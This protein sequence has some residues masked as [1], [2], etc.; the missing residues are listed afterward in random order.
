MS[1]SVPQ[2]ASVNPSTLITVKLLY[3]DNTRRFKIPLKELDAHVLPQKLRQLL[4]VPADVNVILERYSDSAGCYI[5][6]DSENNAVY[7]Q[8]YR[9]AK[10]K[11][12]LRIKVTEVNDTASQSPLPVEDSPDYPN[13]TRYSY[14]ETVLSSPLPEG[15]AESLYDLPHD[16]GKAVSA[17]SS[18]M[19][20]SNADVAASEEQ[21][22]E[23]K[24]DQDSLGTPVVSHK[25]PTG[26]FCIDCNHCGRSIPNEHYHCSICDD[27][28]YDL[29][30][31][32]VDS[33]LTCPNENHW[34]IRRIVTDGIV[35]NSITETVAPRKLQVDD[36]EE[37]P[38]CVEKELEPV[39]EPA[40]EDIP[41]TPPVAPEFPVQSEAR[42][43]NACLK[44][45]DETKMVTC[46]KCKDYDLCITCLLKDAH[47]HHPAHNFSLLHDRPF[48]LKNL[49]LSR[50]KPGR[51]YQH[52]AICDGCEKKNVVG[53]R[54]KCLTCPDWDY[55]TECFSNAQETHP[56]HRFAPLYEAIAEP[57]QS[58]EVH[59]G[60]FCDGPL[61][62]NKTVPGYI[63]GVR[64]KCS[65]CYD[66]DFCSNCEALP[67]NTHNRT[68]PMVMLK[69]PVRNV[70]VSTL[71]EDRFGGST[72]TLGDRAQRSTSTQAVNPV[73]PEVP[74]PGV[75]V[76]EESVLSQ[77]SNSVEQARSPSGEQ[78]VKSEKPDNNAASG[79][80]A[81]FMRDTVP[82]STIMPPN[83][84][85][86]Q[87]WTL[88]NP[89][90]LAWPAG[91]NV[92]F[93]GGD[94]MFNVDTNHPLSLDSISAAMESN[95]LSRPL[96][97]G[98]SADFT[99][100][101]KAPSRVGTGISYWR[102]KLPNGM[103]FG[104][105]LW[106]EI[107]VREDAPSTNDST[108]FGKEREHDSGRTESQ[109]IFPKLEKESPEASAHEASI[110]APV[111]PSVSNSSEQDI[112][113]DVASLSL[114][115]HDT[116][117][118]FLT[119]EEYDILDASDQEY[120]D[121]KSRN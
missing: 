39:A 85:F 40:T 95:K 21:Y 119:D 101:L 1:A 15:S 16:A 45:F 68:H 12:K 37:A 32:C 117:T 93:V 29:C 30:L 94:S 48:C 22:R 57:T 4:G 58:H 70:T 60:I 54:H 50:C 111:A 114:G 6:L 84:V 18:P 47:G 53:V 13:Q 55:C 5:H 76:K 112:L 71:Q 120:M 9:A 89:G 7:K 98:Q 66:L 59:Y 34:L 105:R 65:V 14:L 35:T 61:C 106:C 116:E 11:L 56:G 36:S 79:H 91:S 28:D 43:C 83:K 90:P 86:C 80:E 44:E 81:L 88:Y 38:E 20:W 17:E 49:V 87:T 92:R 64:Y 118:G 69:T 110:V 42:I 63:T 73:E 8:L 67:T 99:V 41:E 25:S 82:D 121:A 102:L 26:V 113:E 77:E 78:Q 104:H 10:A 103:P 2:A 109:M 100:T 72:V 3:N 31:H 27:G 62:K 19:P 97:S 108:E 52:A 74:T 23:F 115:D 107:Q 96:E 46:V 51:R 33:G 24:S 75:S